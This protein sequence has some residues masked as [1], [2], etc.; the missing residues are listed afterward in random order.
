MT[1]AGLEAIAG[2]A[3][4]QPCPAET[5]YDTHA[6]LLDTQQPTAEARQNNLKGGWSEPAVVQG[7]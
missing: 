2:I 1:R 3:A 5:M 4:K 6:D 7:T